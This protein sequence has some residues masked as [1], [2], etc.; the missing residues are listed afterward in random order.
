MTTQKFRRVERRAPRKPSNWLGRVMKLLC[1][2]AG[3]IIIGAGAGFAFASFQ[4]IPDLSGTIKDPAASTLIYDYKGQLVTP[5]HAVENRIPIPLQ[6][7]PKNLQDAFIAVEDNRFY[8]HGG[9]DPRGILRAIWSNLTSGGITEGGSTITQQLA[10]NALL[11]QDQS[12]KRKFQE[13]VLAYQIEQKYSKQEILSFYLNQIYF[14]NGAYGVQAAA[15]TYFGKSAEEL[16]LAEAALLAGLPKSPN[17]YSPFDNMK[18][19]KERQA[20]VLEQ[21]VKYGYISQNDADKAKAE[22]LKLT[23]Q[24]KENGT[25][26]P[27]FVDQV[28]Q[29]L[30]DKYGTKTVYEGGLKV[31][32]SLDLDMQKAAEAAIGNSLPT[33]R[34]DGEGIKQPQGAL[35]AMDPA[36]GEIRAMVGGRGDDFFNRAVLAQRQPGS[37]FKPFTYLAAL[38]HGYTAATIL[39]D[40]PFSSG[41]WSPQNYSRRT[42]GDVPLREA[43]IYSLNLPLVRTASDV[44]IDNVLSYAKKMG[45]TSLDSKNDSNLSA[46][47]GGLY[48]GVSPLEM[49]VA[50]GVL[51]NNGVKSEPLMIL[52]VV[53]RNGE[54]L[55]EH[56]PR[57]AEVIKPQ[58][59]YLMT[60]ML[61]GV[62]QRGTGAGANIGRP[63]AGKTGTTDD[64]RDAWFVGYTPNLVA[65]VWIGQDTGGNLDGITGGDLPAQIWRKFM[66]EATKKLPAASFTRPAGLVNVKINPVD[67]LL[68]DSQTK[69]PKDEL[70]IEGTQPK[71][72]TNNPAGNSKTDLNKT[73][74]TKDVKK[75][76]NAGDDTKEP[77]GITDKE[78]KAATPIKTKDPVTAPKKTN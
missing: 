3:V 15:Y 37:S 71:S 51:A 28:L 69:N 10:K 33:Y 20:T 34:T 43:L 4:S 25:I 66:V 52:K 65:T 7:V 40:E 8:E 74:T 76:N 23:P 70:F 16:T 78:K 9:I 11:T 72:S 54:V 21:L 13:W 45:I 63:A 48:H 19:A 31:Y 47:L 38:E 14:G 6:K 68:A 41:G 24:R 27:Y 62:V 17:Y 2:I 5:V 56:T 46:A 32:T 22:E 35:V 44:G 73:D 1:V 57:R 18:S 75:M 55:E 42:Q 30:I 58:L 67:G 29:T 61:E 59:A 36:T 12:F 50:Y 77:S 49:T 39:K 60:N 64:Y 53:G 26:A